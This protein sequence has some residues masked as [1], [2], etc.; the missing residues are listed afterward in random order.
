MIV[1]KNITKYF[2]KKLA[3][4]HISLKVRSNET[5]ALIGPSGCGK[6]TFLRLVAGLERPD[7][8]HILIDSVKASSS[9]HMM[10]PN[11]RKVSMIFQD[12][13][14][15]PHMSVEAHIR[16]VL[17]KDTLP[18]DQYMEK[19]NLILRDVSLNGYNKRY[20][21]QLSGGEKQRLAIARSIASDP[22]Y[23]LMDEPFSNLDPILKGELENFII[24]IADRLKLG[25]IYVTHNIEEVFRLVDKVAVMKNGKLIQVDTK[26]NIFRSPKNTFVRTLLKL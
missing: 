12:L 24:N 22:H 25:I 6:T 26:D 14:L 13:A 16:F 23:L 21:H 3:V 8:G 1:V 17:K 5:F 10:P 19:T 2:N 9:S 18:K 7:D 4:D 15:W 20:P 11:K